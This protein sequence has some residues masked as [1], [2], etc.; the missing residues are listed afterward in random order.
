MGPRKRPM[1]TI[2]PGLLRKDGQTVMPFGVMGGQYQ[3]AGHAAFLSGVLDCGLDVQQAIDAPRH[4]AFNG[5]LALEPTI[6]EPVRD[7]LRRKGHAVIPADGPVGGAQAIWID[8]EQGVLWG[9]SDQRKD[10]C[11]L[12]F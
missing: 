1:H 5:A 12:G 6:G 2:I 11:A 3:A 9:G 4:F 10:G 7:A 8:R